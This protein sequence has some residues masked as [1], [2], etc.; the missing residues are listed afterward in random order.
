MESELDTIIKNAELAEIRARPNTR[1]R[2]L[3]MASLPWDF[4]SQPL[5]QAEVYIGCEN[6]VTPAFYQGSMLSLSILNEGEVTR[7]NYL[8]EESYKDPW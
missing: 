3:I 7:Y 5:E 6:S 2:V 1:Q 4:L 8:L